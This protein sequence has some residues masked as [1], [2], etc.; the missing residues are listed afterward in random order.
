MTVENRTEPQHLLSLQH[1]SPSTHRAG[2]D[3]AAEWDV[4]CHPARLLSSQQSHCQE[5]SDRPVLEESTQGS[6]FGQH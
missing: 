3:V 1:S 4:L 6:I 5:D 2:L